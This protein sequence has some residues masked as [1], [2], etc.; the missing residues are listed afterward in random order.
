M[1]VGS[2]APSVALAIANASSRTATKRGDSGSGAVLAWALARAI[3]ESARQLLNA[4]STAASSS[5]TAACTAGSGAAAT[6]FT[7]NDEPIVGPPNS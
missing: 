3:S 5:A 6:Y 4:A 7:V 2:K 1:T